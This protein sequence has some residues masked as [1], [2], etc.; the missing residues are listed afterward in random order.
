[1]KAH[2][3]LA[4]THHLG[5]RKGWG[6]LSREES[7]ELAFKNAYKA[8]ELDPFDHHPHWIIGKVNRHA[9]N[10][11]KAAA[12]YDKAME[13]NPNDAEM[14]AESSIFLVDIGRAEEAVER[15][16]TAM[17]LNPRH[18]GWF[19]WSLGWAQYF[20]G[21]CEAA[22]ASFNKMDEAMYE[23]AAVLVCL[24]RIEEARTVMSE[25]LE[26]NPDLTLQE[27][28]D[29]NWHKEYRDRLVSD[30]RRAGAPENREMV[31]FVD[32]SRSRA[33]PF[34]AAMCMK[35]PL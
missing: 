10:F 7:L 6:D 23:V 31:R 35:Q 16:Q 17:R 13:I 20:A 8:R 22:L 2:I 21:R 11:D 9:G 12:H 28:A 5:Y 14:L 19:Y 15:M 1:M 29:G 27:I 32:C 33:E 24:D 25:V 3:G 34:R 4:F 26:K 18:A 30:L